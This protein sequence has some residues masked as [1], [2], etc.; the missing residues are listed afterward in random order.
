MGNTNIRDLI[1]SL[2][3]AASVCV[4]ASAQ[5]ATKQREPMPGRAAAAGAA[6]E[7]GGVSTDEPHAG[8]RPDVPVKAISLTLRECIKMTLANNLDIQIEELA[9]L[10]AE[11]DL[12]MA[13]ADFEPE[14]TIDAGVADNV[15]ATANR[16][17]V[18]GLRGGVQ[19]A[20]SKEDVYSFDVAVEQP[21]YTGGT[22][23]LGYGFDRYHA[24]TSTSYA[25]DPRWTTE[26]ALTIS[27]PLLRGAGLDYNLATIRIASNNKAVSAQTLRNQA[28]QAVSDVEEAYW[29]LVRATSDLKVNRKSLAVAEDLRRNN[30]AQVKAGTMAPLE[31]LEA[32]AGFASRQEGA[33]VAANTVRDREDQLKQVTNL[34]QDWIF[35]ELAV[36]PLDKPVF[37]KT[38]PN[39]VDAINH[40]FAA[41]PDLRQ[42]RLAVRNA[43][44]ALRQARNELLPD[45]T[46]E[47]SYG[48]NGLGSNLGNSNDALF[49]EKYVDQSLTMSL[50]FPLG[51][52]HA[53]S[54][55]TKAR[56]NHRRTLLELERAR[57]QAAVEVRAAT[58]LIRTNYERIRTT[59]KAHQLHTRRLEA[60]IKKREV[61]RATSLDVLE[62]EE[63]R[64]KADRDYIKALTDYQIA[65]KDLQ[66]IQGT[67]LEARNVEVSESPAK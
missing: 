8:T 51:N 3:L 23:S 21:L 50:T 39:L 27:H 47:G 1:A 42:A 17:L 18:G 5:Q 6:Q 13:R 20:K 62:V 24:P 54:N 52:L 38:E 40:A 2:V 57:L 32:E 48:Y 25:L 66:R 29:N 63:D 44:I 30:A 46:I 7:A 33:I 15:T 53:R 58:R 67:L 65:L 11:Q 37:Q 49:S 31:L 9:P 14:L 36:K 19:L 28:L 22:L 60:E 35:S 4:A 10:I 64:A 61:G 12:R 16:L 26:I 34:P 45:L 59:R 55:R 43:Q 41:R 56:L